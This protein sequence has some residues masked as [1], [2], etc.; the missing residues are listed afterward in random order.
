MMHLR[1]TLT[2]GVKIIAIVCSGIL[3][4]A[5]IF[6]LQFSILTGPFIDMLLLMGVTLLGLLFS[7]ITI[8]LNG[9]K[10]L[11]SYS[12]VALFLATI[13]FSFLMP[14]LSVGHYLHYYTN[15]KNLESLDELSKEAEVY[16]M[17]DML[18]YQKRLNDKAISNEKSYTNKLELEKA[19][20]D[21]ITEHNLKLEQISELR[22]RLEDSEVISL[23]RTD[24]YFILTV[25]GFVDNEY[26][27]VKAF[28]KEL[29]EGDTMPPY[30]FVIVRLIE[31][32]DGWY[33]FYT[34]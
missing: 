32:G 2:K 14:Q 16:K 31:F 15:R 12:P 1:K 19:F 10:K 3:L 30:G 26:G 18:R 25:D 23:Q 13:C 6:D 11:A 7:L 5:D 27:Y 17:T 29:K 9:L 22:D 24:D 21:Y 8:P 34:T 28:S 20:G 33:F 4:Y